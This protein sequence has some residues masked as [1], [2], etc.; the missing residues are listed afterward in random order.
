MAGNDKKLSAKVGQV[1]RLEWTTPDEPVVNAFETQTGPPEEFPHPDP[2]PV[3]DPTLVELSVKKGPDADHLERDFFFKNRTAPSV[4]KKEVRTPRGMETVKVFSATFLA[5]HEGVFEFTIAIKSKN[6]TSTQTMHVWR[7]YD[8]IQ[9]VLDDP[10][11]VRRRAILAGIAEFMPAFNYHRLDGHG[12]LGNPKVGKPSGIPGQG[13]WVARYEF[14]GLGGDTSCTMINPAMMRTKYSKNTTAQGKWSFDAGPDGPSKGKG[15]PGWVPGDKDH[16]PSVGD[17][18]IARNSWGTPPTYGHVGIVLHVPENGYG[19]WVMADGGQ[20][21]KPN[22]LALLVPR[23]GLM[24]AQLPHGG[25][26]EYAEMTPDPDGGPFVSGATVSDLNA[27]GTPPTSDEDVAGITDYIRYRPSKPDHLTSCPRRIEG[28]VDV[29]HPGL[30]FS[31]DN[32]AVSQPKE[33]TMELRCKELQQKVENVM[34]AS[35]A[36]K[37]FGG[38]GT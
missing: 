18:Y 36:G 3:A 11:A 16:R 31:L 35:R 38:Q 27:E 20:G 17:T 33:G 28:F 26:G 19:L 32:P 6:K 4:V 8:T 29:D 15:N 22:Q 5:R 30:S 23:W 34:K 9:E 13:N 21:G 2:S 14:D 7:R 1:Y 37:I 24:G 10:R 12:A 25:K